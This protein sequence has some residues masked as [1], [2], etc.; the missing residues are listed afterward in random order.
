MTWVSVWRQFTCSAAQQLTGAIR[1]PACVDLGLCGRSDLKTREDL[2]GAFP[3]PSLR[4]VTLRQVC[5]HNGRYCS[6]KG[7]LTLTL[8][9]DTCPERWYPRRADGSIDKF[10]DLPAFLATLEDRWS[11]R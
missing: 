1:D 3:G 4:N 6:L 5:F 8:Q 7:A 9:R 2:C 10:D 11:A